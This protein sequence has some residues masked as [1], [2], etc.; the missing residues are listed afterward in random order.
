TAVNCAGTG[1]SVTDNA[2]YAFKTGTTSNGSLTISITG[3][4]TTPSTQASCTGAG[5]RISVY[6]VSTCPTGQSF[7]S[8]ITCRT[9][10]GDGPV[11][12]I[13]GLAANHTYLLYFDGLRNTKAKFN[14]TFNGSALPITLSKFTGEFING[15]NQLNIEL[16]Q[17]VNVKSISIE[18]SSDGIHFTQIGDLAYTTTTLLG[19][20]IYFDAQPFAG[21]NYYRLRI[22]DNDGSAE[23]SNI[24]LLKNEAKRLVYIYPNP[25]KDVL[26]VSITATTAAR[27]NCYLYDVS[28]RMVTVKVYDVAEGTQTLHIPFGNMAKGAYV[29]KI[30]DADGNV[31]ARQN[32]IKQ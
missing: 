6:D 18:K 19:K 4:S 7:P 29:I 28:G 2:Y 25:V 24:I 14:A 16:L 21:N 5:V 30:V 11:S 10:T 3:Y 17:A 27:Y 20:H 9:F 15:K 12:N 22:T 26:N 23:Y 8:P 31:A 1:T 32:I 13:T